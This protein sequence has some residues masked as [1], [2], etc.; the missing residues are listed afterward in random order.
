VIPSNPMSARPKVERVAR[1]IRLRK[2]LDEALVAK[3][4]EQKL[5]INDAI[6]SAVMAWLMLAHAEQPSES[7]LV[8]AAANNR[9]P[10]RRSESDCPHPR[11]SRQVFGWGSK[12]GDCGSRL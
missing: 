9:G 10:L 4:A 5:S 3:A 6:A 1:S 2:E 11:K 12:C 8:F 7:G